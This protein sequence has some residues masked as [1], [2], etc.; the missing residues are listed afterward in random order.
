MR[1]TLLLLLVSTG[2]FTSNAQVDNSFYRKLDAFYA[3]HVSNGKV[4]YKA[5]HA[6]QNDLRE[7][8]GII[9]HSDCMDLNNAGKKAWL[10][11]AYNVSVI[12]GII[13]DYPTDSPMNIKGFFDRKIHNLG[14]EKYSLN[15]IEKG[16]LY[17][18]FPDSRLHFALVCA[19]NGCPPLLDKAFRPVS[20]D[21]QLQEV[22]L[23]ALRD[24]NFVRLRDNSTVVELPKIFEWYASDFPNLKSYLN[25][26]SGGRIPDDVTL[27]YYDYDW[28]LN[29]R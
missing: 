4:D 3:Q 12:H 24:D 16:V 14:G 2:L 15:D 20:V 22:T 17:K 11:N 28:S 27:T 21:K 18:Q 29:Q 13:K 26:N 25:R 6:D 19:A 10:I 9:A 7:L 23:L 8:V 5:I 1:I